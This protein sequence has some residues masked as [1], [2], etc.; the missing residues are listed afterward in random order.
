MN[1]I[2]PFQTK[3]KEER[4]QAKEKKQG[5]KIYEE[6]K[7]DERLDNLTVRPGWWRRILTALKT[8]MRQVIQEPITTEHYLRRQLYCMILCCGAV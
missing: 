6:K 5:K 7:E 8:P 3:Q 1:K 4:L 2:G